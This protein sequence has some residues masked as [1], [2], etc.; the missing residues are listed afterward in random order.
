MVLGIPPGREDYV[1][2]G[3]CPKRCTNLFPHDIFITQAA[4]HM[5]Y[6]GIITTII[7]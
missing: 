3:T 4:M 7:T 2:S 5:H 1:E 6:T